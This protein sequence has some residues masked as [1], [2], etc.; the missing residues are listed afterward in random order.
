MRFAAR[1]GTSGNRSESA[2]QNVLRRVAF[3][4]FLSLFF[5]QL[6]IG[7]QTDAPAG[8]QVVNIAT[9][10]VRTA[11]GQIQARAVSNAAVTLV[12]SPPLALVKSADP[13][14]TVEPGSAIRYMLRFENQSGIPLTNVLLKDLLDAAVVGVG[15]ITTGTVRNIGPGTG[16]LT[17][18]GFY[19]PIGREVRWIVGTLPPGFAGEV[20][21]RA[22]LG[23]SVPN[24]TI[25]RNA[26]TL[27]S[28]QDP[29]GVDSNEVTNAV[30][31]PAL[32]LELA[33]TRSRVEVGEPAG[34]ELRIRNLESA[35]DLSD[36][37][38]RLTLPKGFRY[39]EGSYRVDGRKG[40]KP[41]VKAGDR[42]LT[43]EVGD[44]PS[45]EEVVAILVGVPGAEARPGEAVARARARALTPAGIRIASGPAEAMLRV[46]RGDLVHEAVLAGRV[47]ADIDGDGVPSRDEPAIPGV[48]LYL[49]DG[50]QVL[51]D[52]AGKYHIEGI[53][54][55]MHVL[56]ID[57]ETLPTGLDPTRS[58]ERGRGTAAV[59][60]VDLGA[61]ELF[62]AN[63][64][65]SGGEDAYASLR[66]DLAGPE[67]PAS[68]VD[69]DP[70]PGGSG[71]SPGVTASD[72][73]G[74]R[75]AAVASPALHG[76]TAP[77]EQPA[78]REAREPPL[79][80]ASAIFETGS[81]DFRPES[82]EILEGYTELLRQGGFSGRLRGVREA[83]G[84]STV[85]GRARARA[86]EKALREALD[87]PAAGGPEDT[88]ARLA[89]I[90]P[91]SNP[92]GPSASGAPPGRGGGD[93][94][95]A[96][97]KR[98]PQGLYILS[99]RQ[100]EIMRGERVDVDVAF[101]TG[102]RPRLRVDGRVVPEERIGVR[103]TTS[104]SGMSLYRYVGVDLAEGTNLLALDAIGTD[105][106]SKR[107]AVQVDRVG[108]PG[109]ILIRG[110]GGA[111]PAD[112]RTPGRAIVE[113]RDAL[114]HPVADGTLVTVQ[115]GQ[116]MVL[117][118][119][120]DPV[121]EGFQVRTRGGRAS[122]RLSPAPAAE[123]RTILAT[124]GAASG[125][126]KVRFGPYLR[127]WVVAGLGQAD[128]HSEG[129]R[130]GGS[131]SFG[132]FSEGSETTGRL[133]FFAKGRV[134]ERSLLSVSYD[135]ARVRDEDSL[136]RLQD[137][138]KLFPIYG[139]SSVQ[140]YD[141]QSQA[142]LALRWERD[143]SMVT[144]GDFRTGLTAAELARYD[145]ALSG[146]MADVE[147]RRWS[148]HTFGASTPQTAGRDV[149]AADGSSGPYR[150]SR[151]PIVSYSETVIL[152]IRDR[153][154][155]ERILAT[156]PQSRFVDY[157][158]DYESGKILFRSPVPF[159]DVAFNPIFIVITYEAVDASGD[160]LVA[161]GRIGFRP[162]A[163]YEFGTTAVHEEREFGSFSLTG[164]DFTVR[165]WGG[166]AV[167]AEYA[168]TSDAGDLAGAYAV[169]F[170]TALGRRVSLGA[171]VRDVP[172]DFSNP[173]MTGLS[174]MGTH[175]QGLEVR[176][177]LPDGSR[178]LAETFRQERQI[179]GIHQENT[180]VSW[181]RPAGAMTWDV[182]GRALAGTTEATG[183][184]GRSGLVH[185]GVR[186]RLGE[187]LE[188]SLR[189]QQVV[190]GETVA[191]YPTRTDIGAGYRI[192]DQVR[193]FLRHEIDQGDVHT[194][195]RNIIGVEG[196]LNDYTTVESRYALEDAINGSRGY[197]L[198]GVRTRFPI[199]R[200]WTADLRTERSET[201]VGLDGSDFTSFTAGAEYLPGKTKFTG[202]YEV[203]LGEMETRHLLTASGALKVTPDLVL[204][205]RNRVNLS[206]PDLGDS[207]VDA[208][209]LLGLAYRPLDSDKWNWLGRL[210][211]IRGETLPGGGTTL[212]AAPRA[213]GLLS[214]FEL[215][216]QPAPRW[217]LLGRY[218]S[219]LARDAFDGSDVRTYTEIWESRA[220]VDLA[221][222]TT[223]GVT[224]R[225]LRQ[226]ATQTALTGV[227]VE[228]GYMVA[229]D[230]WAV[231]GYNITGFSDAKF[232]DGDR[233]AQGPFFS[234]RFKFDESLFGGLLDSPKGE[235]APR[236]AEEQ[237]RNEPEAGA[238]ASPGLLDP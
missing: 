78:E 236:L 216:Y 38:I 168:R 44:L 2:P 233:R 154:H 129:A 153:F 190:A 175:K 237:E 164:A 130:A 178:L 189:R 74:E 102:L 111:Q 232:P 96:I 123:T 194:S 50:T 18:D 173:S 172:A 148:V 22:T 215:N 187:R 238:A 104:H 184:D 171:Y 134:G 67:P 224:V 63:F 105:G 230:L 207:R 157:D 97:L 228:T 32:A 99:P 188:G 145:R 181:E 85:L 159:H 46:V 128:W 71:V 182:G 202:R 108:A 98:L 121:S 146:V 160:N 201:V 61:S 81:A 150:L 86:L 70:A 132:E 90:V 206:R 169:R 16:S 62:K 59:Q 39:L 17:V 167:T 7:A 196:A 143:R 33:A 51:T 72:G 223:A 53:R 3:F 220:L 24:E 8:T 65:L 14:G 209:G 147:T 55:G 227:G 211:A 19:E 183:E 218:A 112:G 152:E 204:F 28:D 35:L 235:S 136:F 174:E 177:A 199:G 205:A 56:K 118:V 161:G 91:A 208:D 197:A 95:E 12:A 155:S 45:G 158:I 221:K 58:W 113:V 27:V 31:G 15:G 163:R 47:F 226:P 37:T 225:F 203:R 5:H 200:Y 133:A 89:S 30:V 82:E 54:P 52:V 229:R 192:N 73:A 100:G 186:A 34:F 185:A 127:Q 141:L 170:T 210:Q 20:S 234:L 126:G 42:T 149:V 162:S 83:S 198:M 29:N 77:G 214:V 120:A 142:K 1:A 49:E 23:A 119:D 21:F 138:T 219:R 93:A 87:L 80:L 135:S 191:G 222:R 116:G 107:V 114:G 92:A 10:T 115:A 75:D 79:L 137:P 109:R 9:A 68:G 101:P 140:S 11:S 166:A 84:E 4:G 76:P 213:R 212:A 176:A 57:P 64:A 41:A 124:A 26:F 69:E 36:A 110:K 13:P 193:A 131:E 103:M 66:V 117:G 43:V 48:R 217:H 180:S 6:I 106:S 122:V 25:V 156:T 139:D 165:P 94:A 231:A 144:Y 88:G 195:Q 60:F 125:E 40:R 179:Q 151:H